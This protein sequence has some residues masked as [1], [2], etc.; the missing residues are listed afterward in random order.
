MKILKKIWDYIRARS[1]YVIVIVVLCFI[2]FLQ[3]QCRERC[4]QQQIIHTTDTVTLYDT[5]VIVKINYVPKWK[6]HIIY[7]S[8][9]EPLPLDI[10]DIIADYLSKY[11]YI[12]TLIND[13]SAFMVI[14]DTINRNNILSRSWEFKNRRPTQFITNTT[15][16]IIQKPKKWNIGIGGFVGGNKSRFDAGIGVLV[17]TNKRS[18]YNVGFNPFDMSGRIGMYWNLRK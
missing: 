16:T 9:D 2:I 15:T 7:V 3:S 12:D 10:Q 8:N 1:P 13:T 11:V 5:T 4:P 14:T 18:S 17:T 6:D